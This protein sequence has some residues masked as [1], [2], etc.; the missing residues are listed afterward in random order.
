MPSRKRQHYVPQFYLKHFANENKK[1]SI[2]NFKN[3][4]LINNIPY[5]KQC[6]Q[7]YMYGDDN[8]WEV[9]LQ[10]M[11]SNWSQIINKIISNPKHKLTIMD[12]KLLNSFITF[13]RLRT[14]D[15]RDNV[16]RMKT[17]VF[18]KITSIASQFYS[19]NLTKEQ[20]LK[21]QD[22]YFLNDNQEQDAKLCLKIA[23]DIQNVTMDLRMIIGINKTK[24][25]FIS[26]D[27]P[28]LL[29]NP[30]QPNNNAPVFAGLIII[31][32]LSPRVALICIDDKIYPT[33]KSK[34][35]LDLIDKNDIY[36]INILQFVN[37][38]E[39][40]YSKNSEHLCVFNGTLKIIKKLH[41]NIPTT[42]IDFSFSKI[43]KRAIKFS[44]DDQ[45]MFYRKEKNFD[46]QQRISL[47]NVSLNLS[48][49]K[50]LADSAKAQLDENLEEFRDFFNDYIAD[51]L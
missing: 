27:N 14:T 7:N 50:S 47:L 48:K 38:N 33:I 26:S 1:F 32:P 36:K 11:E 18:S 43:H 44:N 46:I 2:V 29:I 6:Y 41:H 8:K 10:N 22:E 23:K 17:E 15:S 51:K 45:Y 35:Y 19:Q 12:K 4:K 20:M 30:F 34:E 31:I 28:V 16:K 37:C 39:L 5:T 40:V 21:M 9:E 3:N 42:G 49:K 25:D 13:Q 24:Y